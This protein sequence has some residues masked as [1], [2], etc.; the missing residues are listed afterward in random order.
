MLYKARRKQPEMCNFNEGRTD[1]WPPFPLEKKIKIKGCSRQ[2]GLY[3]PFLQ[4]VAWERRR[5]VIHMVINHEQSS[6][7]LL[8]CFPA[9]CHPRSGQQLVTHFLVATSEF[10]FCQS[11]TEPS[12]PLSCSCTSAFKAVHTQLVSLLWGSCYNKIHGI[13]FFLS[14]A[15]WCTL[16]NCVCLCVCVPSGIAR[17]TDR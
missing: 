14:I 11:P 3:Y 15:G 1:P 13:T 9:T 12:G 4:L 10:P 8:G 2:Q 17:I 16:S 5:A 7:G 6:Q